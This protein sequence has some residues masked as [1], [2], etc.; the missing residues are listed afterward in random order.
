MVF[1]TKHLIV[2]NSIIDDI[3]QNEVQVVVNIQNLIK[4][5]SFYKPA[6][7]Y[8]SWIL[9]ATGLTGLD[10]KHKFLYRKDI[11]AKELIMLCSCY[12]D[13]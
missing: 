4:T 7:K 10:K 13:F 8:L 2:S 11:T 5:F 3:K 6:Y 9:F 1:D 12:K